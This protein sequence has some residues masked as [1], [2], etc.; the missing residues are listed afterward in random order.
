MN[1]Q[2]LQHCSKD[3]KC[4]SQWTQNFL[5]WLLLLLLFC[6]HWMKDQYL[7]HVTYWG[8][9]VTFSIHGYVQPCLHS[10]DGNNAQSHWYEVE[11]CWKDKHVLSQ[12]GRKKQST[13]ITVLCLIYF[14]WETSSLLQTSE[15]C[16]ITKFIFLYIKKF[17]LW[18]K[19][20]LE[21]QFPDLF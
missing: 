2:L 21:L 8:V 11:Q 19:L 18:I 10:L 16:Q 14:V 3:Q 15:K 17:L 4:H 9:E 5:I 7:W 12:M 20:A 13:A 6:K 1:K